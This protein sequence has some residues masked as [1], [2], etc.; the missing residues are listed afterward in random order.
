[1][2]AMATGKRRAVKR[3]TMTAVCLGFLCCSGS[4]RTAPREDLRVDLYSYGGITGGAEGVTL[5][6]D[7][8]ARFW[9]GRTAALRNSG[10]SLRVDR[11]LEAI[12]ALVDSCEASPF[13]S[14]GRGDLTTVL[15]IHRKGRFRTISFAGEQI[16]DAFPRSLR[17]LILELRNLR[18]SNTEEAR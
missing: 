12:E 18:T 1:M 15:T 16:P 4:E 7:G 10:D 8:W 13:R 6:G 3:V 2:V 14:E 5:T 17:E 9:T 11:K